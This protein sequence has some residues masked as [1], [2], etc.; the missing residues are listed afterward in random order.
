MSARTRF[1]LLAQLADGGVP[2]RVGV[3][4]EAGDALDEIDR[5]HDALVS[6]VDNCQRCRGRDLVEAGEVKPFGDAEV[7]DD[8]YTWE[9]LGGSW[10]EYRFETVDPFESGADEFETVIIRKRWRLVAID[11]LEGGAA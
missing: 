11:E 8:A 4:A 2:E 3:R 7:G 10:G 6:S 5:C 9:N 1:S